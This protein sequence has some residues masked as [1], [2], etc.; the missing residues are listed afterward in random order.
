MHIRNCQ[1]CMYRTGSFFQLLLERGSTLKAVLLISARFSEH[2]TIYHCKL[3]IFLSQPNLTIPSFFIRTLVG[4][5]EAEL[6]YVYMYIE[7]KTEY[8]K[9]Y[10]FNITERNSIFSDIMDVSNQR[11]RNS[12]ST[13][14]LNLLKTLR[15]FVHF[16]V[17]IFYNQND[18]YDSSEYIKCPDFKKYAQ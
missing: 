5:A 17:V 18:L 8:L 12:Q 14:N 10:L 6:F 15:M 1:W 7:P 2:V 9:Q 3:A 11:G 13:Y 16:L 4:V